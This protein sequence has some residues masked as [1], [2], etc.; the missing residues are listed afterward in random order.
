[1]AG[2]LTRRQALRAGMLLIAAT[3]AASAMTACS[4][5]DP[6]PSATAS[7]PPKRGGTLRAAFVGGG[8]AETLNPYRGFTA[9]D[10]SRARALHASLG[11]MDP[12]AP[13]GV[14]YNALAGIDI[15]PD[16]SR[17]TLRLRPGLTFSDG[18]RLTVR[19]VIYSL[20]YAARNA[21]AAA[22][23][24]FAAYFDLGAARVENDT[25]LVLPTTQPITDGRT[26]LCSGTN[27]VFKEGTTA[28]TADMPT[29]GPFRLTEFEAGRG[30]KLVRNDDFRAS[31]AD[32]PYLDG[33]ELLSIADAEARLNALLGKQ[34]DFVHQLTPTQV[35]TW[36]K[37]PSIKITESRAPAMTA[38]MFALNMSVPPFDDPRVRK[39]F[40]LAVNRQQILDTVLFGRGRLGNDLFALGFPGYDGTIEQR[41]HDPALARSLLREAGAQNLQVTL[42]TGPELP[43]MVETATLYVEQLKN[44]GVR[45]SLRELPAGQLFADPAAYAKLAFAGN[46]GP[47][48]PALLYYQMTSGAGNPFAFGWN[49]PDID[50]KVVAARSTPDRNAA[51]TLNHE[52]QRTLWEEGNIV[53][54][55]FKP[56]VNAQVPNLVGVEKGLFEQFPSFAQASLQ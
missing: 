33:L 9:L 56:D 19:D 4:S 55:V 51:A 49:R 17:Y 3:G 48:S 34:A 37:N 20:D 6:A 2:G 30:A 29:S 38:I 44:I 24:L 21:T 5:R 18:S 41:P 25:T 27:L 7:G 42:T 39:A 50:K 15:A 14:R 12:S 36:E 11:D 47:P 8:A 46:Y 26:L 28:F 16:F 35:R 22:S 13:E 10:F 54:P 1:M 32:G 40:K 52:I 43:G 45:A 53:I 23:K 31:G